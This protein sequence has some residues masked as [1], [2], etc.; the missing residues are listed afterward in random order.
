[1]FLRIDNLAERLEDIELLQKWL[2]YNFTSEL[3]LSYKTHL[4]LN[5]I[6]KFEVPMILIALLDEK[7]VG[8]ISILNE[9]MIKDNSH[10]PWIANMFVEEDKR[11]LGIGTYMHNYMLDEAITMGFDTL[12]LATNQGEYFENLGWIYN[13]KTKETT[14]N[15]VKVY[16]KELE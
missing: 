4:S 3:I 2:P 13:S 15:E 14:G 16:M 1:M 6:N 5:Q 8:T 10:S 9:I 7:P 12:Y 11:N